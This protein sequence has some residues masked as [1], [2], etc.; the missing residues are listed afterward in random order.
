MTVLNRNNQNHYINEYG[1]TIFL[2]KVICAENTLVGQAIGKGGAK[3]R[4]LQEYVPD[5]TIHYEKEDHSFHIKSTSQSGALFLKNFLTK[6]LYL[7]H[8][9]IYHLTLSSLIS[10]ISKKNAGSRI[11]LV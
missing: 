9:L 11:Y 10:V 3:I 7:C 2:A 1:Q 6:Q 5:T 4:K 8:L